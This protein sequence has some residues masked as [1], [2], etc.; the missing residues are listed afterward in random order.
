MHFT[1]NPEFISI[2]SPENLLS[3]IEFGKQGSYE[4]YSSPT[5]GSYVLKKLGNNDRYNGLSVGNFESLRE[6]IVDYLGY[7]R[8][9]NFFEI[10][11]IH[12]LFF[13]PDQ[14][15]ITCLQAYAGENLEQLA[16][17]MPRER[18][19]SLFGD[20]C[21]RVCLLFDSQPQDRANYSVDSSPRNFTFDGRLAYVDTMPPLN[22]KFDPYFFDQIDLRIDAGYRDKLYYSRLGVAHQTMVKFAEVDKPLAPV[23]LDVGRSIF[24]IDVDRHGLLRR[25]VD[26]GVPSKD[27]LRQVL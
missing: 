12:S 2:T 15:Y 25:I 16:N 22:K 3:P 11:A 20:I 23:Y 7:F 24:D 1:I 19:L 6:S 14:R 13:N 18:K 27:L 17:S 4:L 26:D 10:P 21:E 8:G 9:H 5:A